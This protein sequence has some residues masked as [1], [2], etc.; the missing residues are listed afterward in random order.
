M[1]DF[2][3]VFFL[4]PAFLAAFLTTFLAAFLAT[5]FLAGAFLDLGAFLVA[6]LA[7]VGMGRILPPAEPRRKISLC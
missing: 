2:A 7:L 6:F 1:A 3:E 4:A 5:F